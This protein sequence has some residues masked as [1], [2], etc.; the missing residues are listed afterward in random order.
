MPNRSSLDAAR[1]GIATAA[2]LGALTA[3]TIL[4]GVLETVFGLDDA[5]AV[6]LLAVVALA[7]WRGTWAGVAAAVGAFLAYN[8]LFVEPRYTFTVARPAELLTLFLLLFVGIVSGRLAG[9]ERDR[10][11]EANRRER[12]ARALFGI[13]RELATSHRLNDAIQSVVMRVADETGMARVWVSLGA[14]VA[15]ERTIADSRS[16]ETTES[17][18]GAYAVLQRDRDEGAATWTRIRPAGPSIQRAPSASPP[19]ATRSSLFRVELQQAGEIV[20]SLWSERP[21]AAGQPEVEETRLLAA[22]ADQICQSIRRDRLQA[23]AA[24]LEIA[25]RSDE[26][27]SALLDSVSHDLRTPLA[28]IRAAAGTLADPQVHLSEA[29]RRSSAQTIDQEADR[30]DRLVGNLLDMSRIQGGA[31]KPDLEVMPLD[32]VVRPVVDRL[33][34]ALKGREVM[35]DVPEDLPPVLVDAVLMDQ[36]VTNLIDNA[37]KYAPAPAPIRIAAS[38]EDATTVR[39]VIEDGGKGVP[40][41]ALP[42]LFDKFYRVRR[43]GEGSRRGT[44][45]GLSVVRGLIEAMGGSVTA[46]HGELGGLRVTVRLPIAPTTAE[47]ESES[48][49]DPG[50]QARGRA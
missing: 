40:S 22:A 46:D 11:R 13:S 35:L 38:T 47:S 5:S 29:D 26:L 4:I 18:P 24:E 32:E 25:R 37:I 2:V 14:N 42:A 21:E 8:F 17:S 23:Q 16:G 34:P 36:V 15:H 31:L 10:E 33:H 3:A 7:I 39:L 48:V 50:G 41:D 6:Y 43:P 1:V 12:E 19:N 30:L 20:G 28:T 27:K 45:L 49:A 44:G 9:L